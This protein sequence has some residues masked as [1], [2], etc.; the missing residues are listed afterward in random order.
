[1]TDKRILELQTLVIKNLAKKNKAISVIDS[2]H[3]YVGTLPVSLV[4]SGTLDK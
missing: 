4:S 3:A 2:L 1:M